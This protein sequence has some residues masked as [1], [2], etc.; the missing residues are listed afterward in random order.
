MYKY[1]FQKQDGLKDCGVASVSMIIKHYNGFVNH[2][3]LCEMTKTNKNG[4]TA[5]NLVE[6]LKQLGFE[7]YGIHYALNKDS[8][9]I[10]L[11][12]IAHT[13]IN[14]S[15]NHFMVIY[16][17]NYQHEYLI[18]ADPATHIKKMTFKEF[19][20]IFTN[21]ILIAYPKRKIA[22]EKEITIKRYLKDILLNKKIILLLFIYVFFLI[23]S[24]LNILLIKYLLVGN[25]KIIYLIIFIVLLKFI[26][27]II[28]NK[29]V[30]KVKNNLNQSLMEVSFNDVLSLPYEYYRNRTTGEIIS[31]INDIDSIKDVIDV[32]LILFSDI[33]ITL[34]TG[35]ILLLT[36]KLLFLVVLFIFVLYLLNYLIF[37]KKVNFYIEELKESKSILNS[38][39]TESVLGFESIKGQNLENSFKNSFK[40]KCN[41]YLNS[42]KK[43]QNI[44][45][46]IFNLNELISD[47]S[48]LL[49]LTTGIILINK[50]LFNYSDLIIFY[51]LMNY[52]LE[53]VKNTIEL[54]LIIN[55]IKISLKRLI[56]LKYFVK[57]RKNYQ[58]GNI[59]I[60]N[61]NITYDGKNILEDFNLNIKTGE[62]IMLVGH[63]GCGKSSILKYLKQYYKTDNI[64]INN[65]SINNF[66]LK[67]NITYISQNEYLFTDTLYNNITL[68]K[69][70]DNLDKII[71][72]C[73]LKDLINKNPL[74]IYTL[75]EENGFNLSGGERQ[76]IILA[77]ALINIKD[78]LFIDEGLSEVDINLER[79]ILKKIFKNYHNKTI[80][81]VSHRNDNVDLFDKLVKLDEKVVLEKNKGGSLC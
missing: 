75:I 49:I 6:T 8:K 77:R 76:R 1:N 21:I 39:M 78:Y 46:S 25:L 43:Y 28:K 24:F 59:N 16:E 45:N 67:D 66:N 30:L 11:P 9:Q 73:E 29:K 10:A 40:D 60:N 53:P 62:K 61:L 7:S 64:F 69:K 65:K 23:V 15:Y 80:I 51:T 74:G 36:N 35:L 52:F 34:I 22:K 5:Y 50:N 17:I 68:G 4:T 70:V 27:N 44:K 37:N 2:E 18:V 57:K 14:N 3:K 38:Y 32:M 56:D 41:N 26:L 20:T 31:R 48:I 79:R 55:E 19:N 54:N 72:I 33:S 58:K 13:I 47:V 63:S 71:D 81:F 42:L 12:A